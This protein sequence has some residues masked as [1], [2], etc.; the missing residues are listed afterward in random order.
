MM[1]SSSKFHISDRL[2]CLLLSGAFDLLGADVPSEFLLESEDAPCCSWLDMLGLQAQHYQIRHERDGHGSFYACGIFGDL[3]LPQAQS[4]FQ[5]LKTDL[6]RPSSEINRYHYARCCHREIGHEQFSLFGAVVTPPSTEDHGDI[7]KMAQLGLFDEGPEGPLP[8]RGNQ[9]GHPD[10]MVMMDGQ[11]GDDIPQILAIGELPGTGE[12]NDKEPAAGLNGLEIFARGI[13]GIG[14]HN[15]AFA[16]SWQHQGLKH[17]PNQHR[18]RPIILVCFRFDQTKIQRNTVDTP[19]GDEEH[20]MQPTGKRRLF[21]QAPL[22][23]QGI[24]LGALALQGAIHHQIQ[25]P[26]IR[27]W[28]GRQS[29]G[30]QPVEHLLPRPTPAGQQSPQVPPA[31]VLGGIAA[32]GFTGGLLKTDQMRRY[33]PAKDQ[34]M[35][36][37]EPSPQRLKKTLYFFG[38]ARYLNHGWPL[39]ERMKG[40]LSSFLLLGR[41]G[42]Q[43]PLNPSRDFTAIKDRT[44]CFSKAVNL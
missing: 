13:G 9:R 1:Y 41:A 10:S 32:Q 38:Q 6:H 33:Q 11:V 24:F 39:E 4:T 43:V 25:H 20:D 2:K 17:V 28:K 37:A 8:A 12:G 23:D 27:R 44:N 3:Y 15:H 29:L 42:Q 22:L 31:N 5:F 30:H 14:D 40:W 21:I 18:L 26:V 16:P 35:A 36:V 7:A 34:K 19:L